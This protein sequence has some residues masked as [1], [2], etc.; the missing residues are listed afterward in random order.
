MRAGCR[1]SR[2]W[3]TIRASWGAP[4]TEPARPQQRDVRDRPAPDDPFEDDV[5]VD[6]AA[7]GIELHLG[8][9]RP[10][11]EAGDVVGRGRSQS[12]DRG[13]TDVRVRRPR[14]PRAGRG[15]G[16]RSRAGAAAGRER[17]QL[18]RGVAASGG[19]GEGPCGSAAVGRSG[20]AKGRRPRRPLALRQARRKGEIPDDLAGG[21]ERL[22]RPPVD[23][24][25]HAAGIAE[26]EAEA[27]GRFESLGGPAAAQSRRRWDVRRRRSPRSTNPDR[28]RGPSR[29]RRPASRNRRRALPGPSAPVRARRRRS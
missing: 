2:T 17:L 1:S 4:V 6:V 9:I 11:E 13:R 28:T 24:D 20:S 22:E 25:A 18:A 14:R 27:V 15:G 7:D 12:L 5:I 26:R 8:G 23:R 21:S 29:R 19:S 10:V 16:P 3:L